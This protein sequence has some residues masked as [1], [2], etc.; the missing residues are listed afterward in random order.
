M[1]EPF[2]RSFESWSA[3]SIQIFKYYTMYT[4]DSKSSGGVF[5]TKD[6]VIW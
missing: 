6:F 2:G 3:S 1:V 4:V 5:N